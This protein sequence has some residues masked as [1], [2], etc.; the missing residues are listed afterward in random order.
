M[1]EGFV[2]AY[3]ITCGAYCWREE[4]LVVYLHI[5]FICLSRPDLLMID[6][7]HMNSEKILVCTAN[8]DVIAIGAQL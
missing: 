3:A 8:N 1:I 6:R 5:R 4:H 7:L 2:Q